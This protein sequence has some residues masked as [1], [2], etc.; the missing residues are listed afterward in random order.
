MNHESIQASPRWGRT[1]LMF[2][3]MLFAPGNEPRKVQKVGLFGA[4]A[5]ILDLEDAVPKTEKAATRQSIYD[6][7]DSMG[8]LNVYVRANSVSTGMTEDDIHGVAHPNLKGI[9][10]PKTE[11]V[12]EVQQTEKW[13][14]DAER[15]RGAEPGSLQ[16][17]PLIETTKGITHVDEIV[18][19][20]RRIPTVIFGSGDYMLDLDIPAFEWTPEGYELFYARARLIVACRAAKIQR[21]VDGPY[22]NVFDLEGLEKEAILSKKIGFQGKLCIHPK[23]VAV[24]NEVFSPDP[25]DVALARK[26][27]DAFEDAERKGSASITVDGIFI[28]Y[29]IYYKAQRIL[30][31]NR[32]ARSTENDSSPEV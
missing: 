13:L 26:V 14:N 11:S 1:D 2:R 29:P 9:V 21:P 31:H 3:S 22:L 10:L 24:I 25:K 4:D 19:A 20:S 15:A 32:A 16:C 27:V 12:E 28:D 30:E 5:V 8:H 18:Q 7:L 17:I 23:H 6:T